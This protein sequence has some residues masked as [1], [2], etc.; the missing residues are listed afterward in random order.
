VRCWEAG[1]RKNALE[2]VLFPT[3]PVTDAAAA[4]ER[5]GQKFKPKDCQFL[6]FNTWRV[7]ASS[8]S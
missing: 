6:T 8:A 2:W 7:S 3:V 4:R 5:L 1:K